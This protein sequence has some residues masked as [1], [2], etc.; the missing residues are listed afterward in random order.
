MSVNHVLCRLQKEVGMATYAGPIV[1]PLPFSLAPGAAGIA[2]CFTGTTATAVKQALRLAGGFGGA[3]IGFLISAIVAFLVKLLTGPE[4]II[5]PA[6]AAIIVV[7]GT[8][9]GGVIGAL[10]A[11]LFI[12]LGNCTCPPGTQGVCICVYTSTI[13]FTLPLIGPTTITVPTFAGPCT[14]PC[15]VL[16]PPGCP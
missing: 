1:P 2:V 10:G 6:I 7:A 16:I 11:E 13:A 5:S 12:R 9:L 15:T 4:P 8:L 14:T 3:V